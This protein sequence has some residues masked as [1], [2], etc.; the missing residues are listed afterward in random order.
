[1]RRVLM[2]TVRF[3]IFRACL[4]IVCGIVLGFVIMEMPPDVRTAMIKMAQFE[5][6]HRAVPLMSHQALIFL[7]AL[8]CAM[9]G[10]PRGL[11]PGMKKRVA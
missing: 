7:V 2:G 9:L 5:R 1:M 4:S 8:S 6:E 3:V 11:L 10:T